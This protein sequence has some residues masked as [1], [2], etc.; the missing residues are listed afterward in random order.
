MRKKITIFLF[1]NII[2]V[3]YFTKE[4][5]N[6]S[7]IAMHGEMHNCPQKIEQMHNFCIN[8]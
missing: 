6:Y 1:N 2:Y 4:Y 5:G 3:L 7:N 8:K